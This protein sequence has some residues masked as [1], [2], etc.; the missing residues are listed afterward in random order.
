MSPTITP[1][2]AQRA[3]RILFGPDSVQAADVSMLASITQR[4]IAARF[5]ARALELHPDRA[6]A[7]GAAAATLER[8]FKQLHGAYRLLSRLVEDEGLRSSVLAAA[9]ADNRAAAGKAGLWRPE[10]GRDHAWSPATSAESRGRET[11]GNRFAASGGANADAGRG[12]YYRGKVPQSELRFAQFLYYNRVIDWRTM[13]DA[14]TWQYRVRPKFGEIGR[15]YRFMDFDSVSR[16]L[17]TSPQGELFGSTAMRLGILDR[18]QLYVV[19]GKQ[20][21]LNYPIGRYF[22]EHEILTR[23]EIDHLLVQNRRHNL[24]YRK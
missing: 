15:A 9:R 20:H 13:I 4:D 6:G 22:L 14:I 11:S 17:R 2:L 10:A 18:R 23:P 19:L 1:E 8:G 7:L 3:L 21:Q 16:V 5:R 12:M 24:R